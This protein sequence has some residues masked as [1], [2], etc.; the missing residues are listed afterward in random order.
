MEKSKTP[1]PKRVRKV[2]S[3]VKSIFIIF[4]DTTKNSFW[5]SKQSIP[6]TT[7]IFY[8]DYVKMCEEFA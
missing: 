5:Q 4:F 7:V 3:K 8:G 2:K 1:R 6:H